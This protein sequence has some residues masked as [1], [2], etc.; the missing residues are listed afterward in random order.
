MSILVLI[1]GIP[2]AGKST[3]A[4]Q[5]IEARKGKGMPHLFLRE[6]DDFFITESGEYRFESYKLSDA[7]H[8]C[9]N[10]TE[11]LMSVGSDV[12]VANIFVHAWEREIYFKFAER[13][14]YDVVVIFCNGGF[15]D[16]HDVPEW[17]VELMRKEFE[18][19]VPKHPYIKHVFFYD[20]TQ[21]SFDEIDKV[22]NGD[23]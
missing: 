16:I 22:V 11:K 21:K 4:R 20:G 9:Q 14:S 6:T 18:F 17:K 10:E 7:H 2:G 13:H 19:E 8:H 1:C 5:L 15:K 23:E 3:L 12:V